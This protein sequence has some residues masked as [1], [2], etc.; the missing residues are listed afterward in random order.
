MSATMRSLR[1][2]PSPG[3]AVPVALLL[4]AGFLAIHV[5]SQAA[6]LPG[7]AAGEPA[8]VTSPARSVLA[9]AVRTQ[10]AKLE[11]ALG[12][13]RSTHRRV[14]VVDDRFHRRL[15][16]EVTYL[17]PR[18]RPI[19]LL[20]LDPDGRLAAAVHLGY[21]ASL[22]EG[23][24]D[25]VGATA[26]AMRLL[27]D[28][29]TVAPAGLPSV[30]PMMDG[31]MW[32]VTWPRRVEGV[33]VDGDGVTV[34]FWRSGDLHSVTVTERLLERPAT[35]ISPEGAREAF[36]RLLPGLVAADRR[37][38]AAIDAPT[39]HWVAPNDQFTPAAAD[40]PAPTLRLAYVFELR[41]G[42]ASAAII[43]AL[44]VWIDAETGDL[45]GGDVLE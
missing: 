37:A 42:G 28:L 10:A 20:R 13:A 44:A 21:R 11:A 30:R 26:A 14:T 19:G 45:L 36:V 29:G 40:A 4:G 31:S 16:H 32:S 17:D 33:P 9:D 7:W 18:G 25:E 12:L 39:L 43:R 34:R 3:A 6:D 41:F 8:T 35:T 22:G 2:L 27:R 38:D 5:S 1:R 24:L 15:L 23:T